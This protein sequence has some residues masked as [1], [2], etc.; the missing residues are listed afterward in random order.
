MISPSVIQE[1]MLKSTRG[2]GYQSPFI[3][4]AS[5][6]LAYSLFSSSQEIF[7]EHL[8]CILC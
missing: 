8:L 1:K 5:G 3:G 4:L 7:I 6:Q 2:S